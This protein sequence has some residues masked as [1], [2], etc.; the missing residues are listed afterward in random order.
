MINDNYDKNNTIDFE[1]IFRMLNDELNGIN[2]S[3]ELICAGGYVMQLN[4]Y[5]GT[6]D[7][8]A[9]YKSSTAYCIT[10]CRSW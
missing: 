1:P 10:G 6:S 7:V 4:G 2:E 8:D 3:L 5:R 9:F